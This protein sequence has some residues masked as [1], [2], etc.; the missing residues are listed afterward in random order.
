M[1]SYQKF[2]FPAVRLGIAG[3]LL[4]F[5]FAQL[6]GESLVWEAFIPEFIVSITGISAATLVLLNALSEII[7]GVLILLGLFTR[8]AALLMTL[9]IAFIALSLGHNSVAVRDWGLVFAI[10]GIFLHGPDL[11]SIDHYLAKKKHSDI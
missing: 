8:I 3:V 11:L 1:D 4:W 2:A 7:F 9:H 10:L 6:L 5:G